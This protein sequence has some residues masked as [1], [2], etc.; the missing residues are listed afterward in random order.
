VSEV[1]TEDRIPV[2]DVRKLRVGYR[3]SSGTVPVVDGADLTLGAGQVLA[4]VGESGSGKTTIG[5]SI[6]GLLAA[7][8]DVLA[9]EIWH[10]GENLVAAGTDRMR[11][12]RGSRISLIP[13]DPT[14][15]LNPIK[16]IGPQIEDVLKLH[17]D[18]N[19]ATRRDHVHRLLEQVGFTDVP[20]R[21]RQYPH[22][23]SGGM[24]QRV[25][26]A[27][28]IAGDPD[29]IVADE[30]T[31]GL[32][33]TV[34]KRILDLLDELR[35]RTGT[36]MVLITHDLGVAADRSD[37]IAVM[38]AGEIV[39][40]G[41]TRSVIAD[42]AHDY[43]QHL[44][45]S[46]PTLS[47]RT[48]IEPPTAQDSETPVVLSARHLTKQFTVPGARAAVNAV[49]DVSF[50]V[51]RG[52]T[53]SI[54]GES[55]SGKSTTA[56]MLVRLTEP[57]S[58]AIEILGTDVTALSRRQF[59]RHRRDIQIVYQN[60]YAAFDPRFDLFSIIE[61]P[62]R[63]HGNTTRA[64]RTARVRRALDEVALPAAYIER[65]PSELSG[66][67]RQR[68]AIARALVLEPKIVVLDEPVSALDV[69]V[70]DQ[71]LAL[72]D[73]LQRELDLSYVF[74]SHDLA[75]V[76]AISDH[77]AVMNQGKIVEYGAAEQVFTD[78]AADYTAELLAAIPGRG[79]G[80]HNNT[81]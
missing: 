24:R 79:L 70:Q 74:I 38:R 78:P 28:A 52:R 81:D 53:L 9:G 65:K 71:I 23:L 48:R 62:L 26:I 39:E 72:L 7:N 12:L 67:Q 46:A 21:Y 50:D 30:P 47:R 4:L 66:G 14:V 76:R 69:S 33:V 59:R 58:G 73:R 16:R 13:Q 11:A 80:A 43:S 61:E 42:P 64:E 18:E 34:Q 41:E 29:L 5:Q 35:D 1:V 6:L 75:V 57:T 55:G 10:A 44:L 45:R 22:E 27:I 31:S 56:R 25:L 2:L 68:V 49:D 17:T 63:A 36:S 19:R 77:V 3:T 20:R 32:D 51:R 15:S 37:R 54:V 60:P 8:G 40:Q